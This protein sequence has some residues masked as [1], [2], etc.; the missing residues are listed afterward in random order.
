M[1][2]HGPRQAHV[3][4]I[5][6]VG[7]NSMRSAIIGLGC[8]LLFASCARVEIPRFT[9][10]ECSA[11][12]V[13]PSVTDPRKIE[14][15]ERILGTLPGSWKPVG[16]GPPKAGLA[17]VLMHG[18]RA[19]AQVVIGADWISIA[20]LDERRFPISSGYEKSITPDVR[21]RLVL[22][23]R[24]EPNQALQP[25]RM[26]VTIRAYARLAPSIRVADLGR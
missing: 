19:V 13:G 9:S 25:T 6:D 21:D 17:I 26:L 11:D 10:I 3:W 12:P 2:T 1:L 23:S 20:E 5:F 8:L 4:L 14:E 24:E 16:D 15:V 7:Q 22:L 18:R